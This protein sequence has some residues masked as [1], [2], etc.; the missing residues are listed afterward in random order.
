[1]GSGA[2]LQASEAVDKDTAKE[3]V[4]E[5]LW[6]PRVESKFDEMASESGTVDAEQW[7][8]EAAHGTAAA[9]RLKLATSGVAG[10]LFGWAPE[11]CH[12]FIAGFNRFEGDA[13]ATWSDADRLDR[14]M[15][16][17]LVETV[18][19]PPA[20]AVLLMDGDGTVATA[21]AK[22]S[23]LCAGM[24]TGDLLF[25][26]W[27]SHGHI[28][29]KSPGGYDRE[30]YSTKAFD[31]WITG[32]DLMKTILGG[33]GGDRKISLFWAADTCYSGSMA[34]IVCE[35]ARESGGVIRAAALSSTSCF[36]TAWSSWRVREV[37][38]VCVA[39]ALRKR[40][41]EKTH[42][43]RAC[44]QVSDSSIHF[45]LLRCFTVLSSTPSP[46]P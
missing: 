43:C 1:M 21:T 41:C 12:V 7:N 46:S 44:S 35:R 4:G 8:D 26:Y 6:S 32:N 17:Y 2:S 24:K 36:Q 20:Q 23:E 13:E 3:L 28:A 37:V 10:H 30:T 39:A 42:F 11:N 9:A 15:H 45:P 22:L 40:V 38:P 27:G 14:E 16:A 5:A 18:G 19:V 34:H 25:A 31:G 29:A 33:L